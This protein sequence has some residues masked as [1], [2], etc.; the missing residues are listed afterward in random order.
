MRAAGL[1]IIELLLAITMLSLLIVGLLGLLGRLLTNSTKASD[2]AAGTYAGQYLLEKARS[3]GPPTGA[4]PVTKKDVITL[5]NHEEKQPV[6]FHYEMVW[7]KIGAPAVDT[8]GK[9][10][11]FEASL[12]QVK[13]TLWWMVENAEDGRAEGGG[14]RTVSLERIIKVGK[15][16]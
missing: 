7:T 1:T 16:S 15:T 13:I 3:E 11:K 9:L 2:F 8:D 4:S 12:Y 10:A 6:E 5:F 14:K